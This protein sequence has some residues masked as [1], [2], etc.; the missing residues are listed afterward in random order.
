MTC[1]DFTKKKNEKNYPLRPWQAGGSQRF[2]EVPRICL[3][4]GHNSLNPEKLLDSLQ[5]LYFQCLFRAK[6]LRRLTA[7]WIPR[8]G[9]LARSLGQGALARSPWYLNEGK[10]QCCPPPRYLDP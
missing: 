4:F 1:Q 2:P 6:Q 10:P 9:F 5:N 7:A 3:A 8:P